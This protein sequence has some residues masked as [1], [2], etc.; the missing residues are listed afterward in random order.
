MFDYWKDII[1]S[2]FLC[3]NADLW[4]VVIDNYT[5]SLDTNGAKLERSKMNDQQNKDNKNHHK[6]RTILLNVI[7]YTEYENITNIDSAKSI[8]DSLDSWRKQTSKRKQGFGLD[9]KV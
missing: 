5:H 6:S 7:S 1:K 9:L 8:F 3:Y 4:D 2:L